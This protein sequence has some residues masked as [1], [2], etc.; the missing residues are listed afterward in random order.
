MASPNT[1]KLMEERKALR[2][3]SFK[4]ITQPNIY[5][6]NHEARRRL[7]RSV[8]KEQFL[9][10]EEAKRTIREEDKKRLKKI[11]SFTTFLQKQIESIREEAAREGKTLS[12]QEI[13]DTITKRAAQTVGA[14]EGRRQIS[15]E[16]EDYT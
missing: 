16:E 1:L 2:A 5:G 13:I 9:T 3:N 15:G 12:E 14:K 6:S 7:L 10:Y 4:V 8:Y 11:G